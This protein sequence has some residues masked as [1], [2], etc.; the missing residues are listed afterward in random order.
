VGVTN[1]RVPGMTCGHCVHAVEA[2]VGAVAGV[3][4]VRAD[5]ET[6]IVSVEGDAIE[7]AA[8]RAAIAEAGYDA[9]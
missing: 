3:S 7:D 2:E 6:K 4:G 1:Y 9:E 8:V 5:L